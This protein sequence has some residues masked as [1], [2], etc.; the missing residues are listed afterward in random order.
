MPDLEQ[1]PEQ[2]PPDAVPGDRAQPSNQPID[3]STQ[4]EP[5]DLDEGDDVVVE[6]ENVGRGNMEGGGEWPDPDALP[7]DAAPGSSGLTP[8]RR[9]GRTQFKDAYDA[10]DDAAD[11]ARDDNAFGSPQQPFTGPDRPG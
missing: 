10:V 4:S 2:R 7:V 8:E 1:P 3:Q 9:Q 11:E 5:L 6:Q